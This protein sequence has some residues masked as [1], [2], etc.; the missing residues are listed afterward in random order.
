MLVYGYV[1]EPPSGEASEGESSWREGGR[2][3]QRVGGG[4]R[5]WEEVEEG[6]RRGKRVGEG[7]EGVGEGVRVWVK[8]ERKWEEAEEG[9][10]R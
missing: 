2:R 6:G 10:R 4:V 8:E 9:G 5:G 7:R 1:L 3:C